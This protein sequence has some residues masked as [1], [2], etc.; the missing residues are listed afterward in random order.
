MKNR[1]KIT[2]FSIMLVIIISSFLAACGKTESSNSDNKEKSSE[3]TRVIKH[4][5]GE[6]PIVGE[7]KKIV[8][9]EFSFVD[10]L[11]EL[12]V[13]PVGIAH[14]ND[15]DVEGLL[16]QKIKY[17]SVGTR[18]QPN[19]EAISALQ[20]D[21]I[22]GDLN[23]HKDIYDELSK[24]APTIILKSRNTSYEENLDS[25]KTIAK[26]LNKEAEGEKRL[27]KHAEIIDQ[28]KKEVPSDE[29]RKILIGVFRADSLSAH[30]STSFGGELLEKIGVKNAIQD[31]KEPTFNINLEQ[32]V[33]W[34]PDVIF[35]AEAD[36]A[37]LEEWKKNPLW[38]E[39]AAVK[40]NQV[41][42]VDRAL[43]TRYR[44]LKSAE[45]IVEEATDI[46]YNSN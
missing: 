10:G 27:A 26:T 21:L 29:N 41:Y 14:E 13:A 24:I 2:A 5:L 28:V 1:N 45:K 15:D 23:R 4:E 33:E 35:M 19:L 11:W 8:A 17:T 3:E 16:G 38:N 43:W 39:I 30:G 31:A 46:L 36:K 18:Q 12:G 22:I 37:L 6:T 20:P 34:N 9:L 42:E 7:P 25:F 40:N 32:M 44:G